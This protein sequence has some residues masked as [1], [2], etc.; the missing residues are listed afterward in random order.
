MLKHKR[1]AAKTPPETPPAFD[2]DKG[3][4]A[5]TFL[6]PPQLAKAMCEAALASH[7]LLYPAVIICDHLVLARPRGLKPEKP[8]SKARSNPR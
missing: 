4:V 5:V 6:L 3:R 7:N 2:E 8:A 1:L